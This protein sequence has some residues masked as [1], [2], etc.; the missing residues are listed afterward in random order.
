MRE[1]G[2]ILTD[3]WSEHAAGQTD[4]VRVAT[5]DESGVGWFLGEEGRSMIQGTL[6]AALEVLV[7][8]PYFMNQAFG[9]KFHKFHSSVWN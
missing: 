6:L 7:L 1:G 3:K 5:R 8:S 4:P 2:P 9:S